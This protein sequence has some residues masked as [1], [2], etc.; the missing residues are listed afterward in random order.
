MQKKKGLSIQDVPKII[1]I[2]IDVFLLIFA[3]ALIHA[4]GLYDINQIWVLNVGMDIVGMMLGLVILC[5]SFLDARR[6]ISDYRY[7]RYMLQ[8]AFIGIFVDIGAWLVDGIPELR[9]L[10]YLDNLIFYMATPTMVFFF[11]LYIKQ[12]IGR[13]DSLTAMVDLLIKAG[14]IFE[15][16]LCLLNGFTGVFFVID[17][18]GEYI[19]GPLYLTFMAFAFVAAV[20]VIVI[21]VARRKW[22]TR[23]QVVV[24]LL[25]VLTPLPT[26]LMSMLVYGISVNNV[27]VMMDIL[28]MYAVLNVEQGKEKLALEKELSTAASIQEGVLPSTFPLFP[29][30]DEF[31]LYA[32]MDPAKEI[33]GDFYDVFLTDENHLAMVVGDVAGK[34]IPAALFMLMSRTLIKNRA[35]MGGTPA[36]IIRDVNLQLFEDNKAKMFVTIWLVI[37]DLNTGHVMEVN[38]GHECPAF[39]RGGGDFELIRTKH[40]LV[41]GGRKKTLYHDNEYDLVPG[42]EIFIYTDGVPEATN[43]DGVMFGTDR[44]LAALNA[45]KGETPEDLVRHARRR[46]DAFV[47]D[48]DQFDDLTMLSFVYLGKKEA[49]PLNEALTE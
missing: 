15:V 33:G 4:R 11:W 6:G 9:V 5:C 13:Q 37:I 1:N 20:S 46:V 23:R 45:H 34:G 21:V 44:M 14:T 10:N 29:D 35:Q 32:S 26:M 43:A 47:G 18:S 30:R 12:L 7:F 28:I 39:K 24:I 49:P 27:I 41:V 40:D 22:F 8:L 36:E 48:A 31:D 38:A 3:I 17:E 16:V 19:R 2:A 25:Y 42:D